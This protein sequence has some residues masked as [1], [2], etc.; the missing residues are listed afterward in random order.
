MRAL[1]WFAQRPPEAGSRLISTASAMY[2]APAQKFERKLLAGSHLESHNFAG[3]F[4]GPFG[5]VYALE[6]A[7]AC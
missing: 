1:E 2:L 3:W 6:V 7:G 4:D 5:I